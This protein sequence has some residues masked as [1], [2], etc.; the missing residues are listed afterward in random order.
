MTPDGDVHCSH[1]RVRL[2]WR[3]EG[4]GNPATDKIAEVDVFQG[5]LSAGLPRTFDFRAQ[6]PDEPWSYSGRYI[7]IVWEIAVDLDVPWSVNPRHSQPLVM[8]PLRRR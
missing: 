2:Q 8:A 1:L 4:R 6:L 5:T 3:T 7:N